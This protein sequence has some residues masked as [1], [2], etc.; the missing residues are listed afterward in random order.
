MGD[1]MVGFVLVLSLH[2]AELLTTMP[3]WYSSVK[4]YLR[5]VTARSVRGLEIKNLWVL[6]NFLNIIKLLARR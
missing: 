3:L 4:S 2:S 5:D 1:G 6:A